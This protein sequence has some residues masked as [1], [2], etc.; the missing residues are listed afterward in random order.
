MTRYFLTA[1]IAILSLT[2]PLRAEDSAK[3][4]INPVV[5]FIETDPWLMVIG[6]DSPSFAMYE[7]GQIIYRSENGY[8]T[9]MASTEQQNQI[10]S[11]MQFGTTTR[12]YTASNSTDQPTNLFLL[13]QENALIKTSVYGALKRKEVR[14]NL[15][16]PIVAAYDKLSGFSDPAATDWLPENIEVMI[17]PY[18]YAPEASIHWPSE[19][20]GIDAESTIKRGDSYSIFLPSAQ[21]EEFKSFLRTGNRKG[22]VEIAGKKWAVSWRLPFPRIVLKN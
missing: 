6:S 15:P 8:K 11:V 18:E 13:R 4:V 17:W 21:F 12:T 10:L 9:V 19:W 22:A 2:L 5:V 7:N 14:A 3:K 16:A 1:A 20:P